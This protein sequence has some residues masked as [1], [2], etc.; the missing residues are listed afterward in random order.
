MGSGYDA[1]MEFRRK[2]PQGWERWVPVIKAA[3][4]LAGD[5][6]RFAGSWVLTRM[7]GWAPSLRS[8][9]AFDIVE[10]IDSTRGGRRAYYRMADR[11]GV[12]RALKELG[13]LK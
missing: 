3:Y 6:E 8:L 2:K 12:G 10:K 5:T 4:E 7:N 11:D 9:A 13:E 1:V